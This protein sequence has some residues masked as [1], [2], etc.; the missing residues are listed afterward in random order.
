MVR[1]PCPQKKSANEEHL[2]GHVRQVFDFF[3]N[4]GAHVF[5]SGWSLSVFGLIIYAI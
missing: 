5:R 4:E 3:N 2:N 1:L